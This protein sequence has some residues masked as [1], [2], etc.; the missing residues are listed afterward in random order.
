LFFFFS[1]FKELFVLLGIFS[2][3]I[4]FLKCLREKNGKGGKR[5]ALYIFFSTICLDNPQNQPIK[6]KEIILRKNNTKPLAH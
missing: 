2:L 5:Q 4:F 3:L 6:S 1:F